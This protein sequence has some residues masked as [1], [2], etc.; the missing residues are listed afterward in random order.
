MSALIDLTGQTFGRI[1]VVSRATNKGKQT[2]WNCVCG[3]GKKV[4]AFGANLKTLHTQSCGCFRKEATSV[5]KTTHGST[6][7]SVDVEYSAWIN[8]KSRCYNKLNVRFDRYG[9]RGIIVCDRWKYSFENFLKDVGKRPSSKHSIDRTNNDLNYTPSNVK[10]ATD[11]EQANNRPQ[12]KKI[13]HNGITL[14][15][16]QW[17]RKL[18]GCDYLVHARI[19]KLNWSEEKAVST[20]VRSF[21]KRHK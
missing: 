10:W 21:K 3:C 9:G 17:S 2:M 12:A 18:N 20:P 13:T 4:I 7:K 19:N 5:Y 6:I 11:E 14:S 16:S 1:T 15:R 8:M